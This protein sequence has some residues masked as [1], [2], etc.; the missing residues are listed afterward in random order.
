RVRTHLLR[1][2]HGTFLVDGLELKSETAGFGPPFLHFGLIPAPPRFAMDRVQNCFGLVP[3][4]G[5]T[6]AN[7]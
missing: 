6:T 7:A 5:V 4:L 1:A 3:I 2:R